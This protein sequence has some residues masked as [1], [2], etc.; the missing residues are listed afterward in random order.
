VFSTYVDTHR[1]CRTVVGINDWYW[2]LFAWY[3]YARFS[4][5]IQNGFL[6][7]D[8]AADS[9]VYTAQVVYLVKFLAF[10]IDG[11]DRT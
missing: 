2:P 9:A 11:A 5:F 6:G 4:F 10:S 1:T 3:A 7:T 8:S